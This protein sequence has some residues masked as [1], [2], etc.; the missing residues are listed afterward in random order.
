MVPTDGSTKSEPEDEE[1]LVREAQNSLPGFKNLYLRWLSPVYRYI[2]Y[3]TGN[4]SDAEDLTSQVFLK[5]YQELPR[6]HSQGR[7]PAWLFTIAR[8]AVIDFY[9][10]GPVEDSIERVNLLDNLSDPLEQAVNSDEI[11]RLN[12]LI[13]SLPDDERELIRL[14][15]VSGLSYREIGEILHRKEDAARKSITRLLAR[16]QDQLEGF[17][18]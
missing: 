2:Y 15:F 7:F 11:R 16:L 6:Y 3:R 13:H 14:R 9:R 4:I 1:A 5:V 10:S 18:G 17:H 12:R 8:N